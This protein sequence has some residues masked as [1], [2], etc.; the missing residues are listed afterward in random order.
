MFRL[1]NGRVIAEFAENGALTRFESKKV[2]VN[3]IA[4]P[5]D[6]FFTMN[7]GDEECKEILACASRQKIRG[8][9]NGNKVTFFA[10]S[11]TADRGL[12]DEVIDLSAAFTVELKGDKLVYTAQIDNRSGKYILDFEYPRLGRIRSLGSGYP[13]LLWPDRVCTFF[14]NAGHMLCKMPKSNDNGSNER[15]IT[16]PGF[17][18]MGMTGLCD[19]KSSLILSVRDKDFLACVIKA[20]GFPEDGDCLS[21]I[22]DKHLCVKNGK[23]HTAP[24]TA[25]LYKGDWRRGALDYAAWMN[26]RRPQ[27][28]KPEWV[29]NMLGYFLVINKQQYGYEMWD[30]DSIPKLY[31][32]AQAHGFDVLGL[33]GWYSTGHDNRYPDLEA[34]DSLGGAEKLREG[35]GKVHELGGKVNLY[36]QGH[37]IDTLSDY[38]LHGEGKRVACKTIWGTEYTEYYIKSHRSDFNAYYSRRVFST[39]CY[40]CP[41]WRELMVEKMRWLASFGADGAIYDQVGGVT[42]Y[43]CFDPSHG[44]DGNNPARAITGGQRKLLAQLHGEAKKIGEEFTFMSEQITDVYSPYLDMV[45][46]LWNGPGTPAKERIGEETGVLV[47]PEVFRLCFPDSVITV[48]NANPRIDRRLSN[49]ALTYGFP[50]ELEIRYA[51]D[52]ND[53]LE[54]RYKEEREYARAVSALRAKYLQTMPYDSF[55]AHEGITNGNRS[56]IAQGFTNGDT[57]AVTLWND[58]ARP[59]TPAVRVRKARLVSFE[60]VGGPASD[61]F[62][63]LPPQ[64]AAIAVFRKE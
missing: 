25:Q 48:R 29:K 55:T 45:H 30:Y 61:T 47:R 37:L 13:S 64:T 17:G 54:D 40:S 35:I 51:Q 12:R 27:F 23:I 33:F 10:D 60:P 22:I 6:D 24:I 7:F 49:Y 4:M 38:Y 31:Q 19:K 52:K 26:K 44:H 1:E 9:Q 3:V 50:L 28:E 16:Y 8:E 39:A 43:I 63:P 11:L 56:L 53:L 14:N 59:V 21:L 58:S 62:A 32:L 34:A 36:Y 42:P 18:T 57:V 5:D 2:G 15:K 46:G 41:E 20:K